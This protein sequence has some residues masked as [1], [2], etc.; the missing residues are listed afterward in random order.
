MKTVDPL[1]EE[2]IAWSLEKLADE[3]YYIEYLRE[4]VRKAANFYSRNPIEIKAKLEAKLT[5]GAHEHGAPKY[6][7]SEV[8][9]ELENEYID[10]IGWRLVRDFNEYKKQP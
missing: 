5:K 3:D 1:S 6:Q 4:C 8:D 10:I 2:F 7:L 9:A